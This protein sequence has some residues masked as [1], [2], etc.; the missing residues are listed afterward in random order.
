MVIT[1]GE[2]MARVDAVAVSEVG[3]YGIGEF[4]LTGVVGSVAV[5][6]T[7]AKSSEDALSLFAHP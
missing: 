1:L 6:E 4:G 5:S 3:L 2:V 7:M